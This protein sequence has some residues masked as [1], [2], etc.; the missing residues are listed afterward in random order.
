[1]WNERKEKKS[2]CARVRVPCASRPFVVPMQSDMDAMA[3]WSREVNSVCDAL[4]S[5]CDA[6]R[7]ALSSYA[8]SWRPRTSCL[9]SKTY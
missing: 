2:P 1:M 4:Y 6:R 8:P 5:P 9:Y 3:T 7:R